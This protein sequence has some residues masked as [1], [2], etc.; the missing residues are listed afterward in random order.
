MKKILFLIA[1]LSSACS[2]FGGGLYPK[3]TS[4]PEF[5]ENIVRELSVEI[6]PR[7]YVHEEGLASASSYIQKELQALGYQTTLQEFEVRGKTVENIIA[8]IGPKDA[9]RIVVGAHYDSYGDQPGADDNASGVAGLIWLSKLLKPHEGTLK[10]RIDFV[11][12]TLEEPP[13]FRTE[14]MGSYVHAKSLKDEGVN[15][16]AMI[17]LEMIGYFSDEPGSQDYPIGIL[18]LFYPGKGK[19]IGV[20]SNMK[21]R[22]LKSKL[23]NHMSKADISVRSLSAPPNLVGVDFSDHLNYWQFGYDAVMITD[24]AFYRN[25][26]YHELT[27]TIDTLD[28]VKMSY[29]VLGVYYGVLNMAMD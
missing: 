13:F 23:K 24:T 8:S 1:A 9:D 6:G 15:V 17:A 22:G 5:L 19:F 28:F 18:R 2:L 3:I 29:A 16:E 7:N 27:D 4:D 21:S 20:I 25:E 11:A 26:N 12:Y 10:K 14:S